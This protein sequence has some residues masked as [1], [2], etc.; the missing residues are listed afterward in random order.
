[1]KHWMPLTA[2]LLAAPAWAQSNVT[3]SGVADAALRLV[4]NAGLPTART[5]ASGSNSTSRLIFRGTEDMGGGLYAGFHLEHGILLDA[6]TPAS[7][8]LFFDRRS[9]VSLGDRKLGELRIGRDFVPTYNNWSR[10]DPFS[11]VGVAG[12]NNFVSATPL[13]PIRSAFGT[14]LATTVRSSNSVQ[15]LMP[16]GWGGLEG[17]AMIAFR[18]GGTAAAGQHDLRGL[19][20]GWSDKQ[21]GVA[22]AHTVSSND[23]TAAGKFKDSSV[24]GSARW[25]D[26]RLSLAWRRMAQS[27][28]RQTHA[29]V[30]AWWTIGQTELRA[31]YHRVN[32]AGR[33][34]TAA[35]DANDANQLGLGFVYHLS[36]RTG[37]YGTA[38]RIDNRGAATFVVPGGTSG[39]AA[40]K[41]S[42]G[43]EFGVRHT[44]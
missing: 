41:H 28:S 13:G 19:R 39:L 18:E 30:G 8:Q 5:V 10:Y 44:F 17:E 12:S 38:S 2:A 20:L 43:I 33:V 29:L 25:G 3:L 23:L 14:G 24:G 1:M 22:A 40:G 9:T 35:I 31:S 15:W 32:F 16:A 42:R 6:G 4:D 21:F 27:Q 34:G 7:A 36:K 11:Y 37:V 26:L